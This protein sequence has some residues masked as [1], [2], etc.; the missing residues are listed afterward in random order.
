MKSKFS[1]QWKSI[2]VG[3]CIHIKSLVCQVENEKWSL[4]IWFGPIHWN[5]KKHKH[6]TKN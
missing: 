6:E 4:F 5:L 3:F 2:G 1:I